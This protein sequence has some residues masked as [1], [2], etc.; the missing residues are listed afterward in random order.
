MF[1]IDIYFLTYAGNQRIAVV[2]I[3]SRYVVRVAIGCMAGTLSGLRA[4]EINS[5]SEHGGLVCW[6]R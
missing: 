5:G 6:F 2:N 4:V 1:I 3:V